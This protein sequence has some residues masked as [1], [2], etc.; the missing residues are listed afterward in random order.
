MV[1]MRTILYTIAAVL[2]SYTMNRYKNRI[3][4]L[5]DQ[6]L[7]I[8]ENSRLV[9]FNDGRF[10]APQYEYMSIDNV[11]KIL[12]DGLILTTDN[13]VFAHY[14]Y[15]RDYT[16]CDKYSYFFDNKIIIAD[17]FASDIVLTY[18]NKIY[19][20]NS[21][22]NN[23]NYISDYNNIVCKSYRSWND[24]DN[25][26]ICCNDGMYQVNGDGEL[27]K[28]TDRYYETIVN[29]GN[30]IFVLDS[31]NKLY[32]ILYDYFGDYQKR[33]IN[34][35][36]CGYINNIGIAL[37]DDEYYFSVECDNKYYF[38]NVCVNNF[39]SSFGSR[40][41]VYCNCSKCYKTD[42]ASRLTYRIYNSN[43]HCLE[44]PEIDYIAHV[45][46]KNLN[47]DLGSTPI[48]LY[49]MLGTKLCNSI[50][51]EPILVD[52]SFLLFY[53]QANTINIDTHSYVFDAPIVDL[54]LI[55]Y[56]FEDF[57]CQIIVTLDDATYYCTS[58]CLSVYTKNRIHHCNVKV[59]EIVPS[60]NK[61][62]V[63]KKKDTDSFHK[64]KLIKQLPNYTNTKSTR[65]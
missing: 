3:D 54:L 60:R 64:L 2:L 62:I 7:F 24:T 46:G 37:V 22:V 47:D 58:G 53:S 17:I 33:I 8:S 51:F 21:D 43:H 57:N 48:F 5:R 44:N 25:I 27:C 49:D 45:N 9:Y 40:T 42:I 50:I 38:Y 6:C 1:P 30:I 36:S 14:F 26:F 18:C 15:V 16:Y 32:Y 4:R 11:A 59:S 35:T 55:Y 39:Q 41:T 63:A 19:L 28:V 56:P 10:G 61:K 12:S 65:M 31:D 13:K 23:W 29:Y 20:Y 34:S 52:K